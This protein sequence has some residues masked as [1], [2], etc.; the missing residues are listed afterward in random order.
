MFKLEAKYN[1][2]YEEGGTSCMCAVHPL[3]V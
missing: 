2:L 3:K 1:H